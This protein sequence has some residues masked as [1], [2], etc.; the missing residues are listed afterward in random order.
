[1]IYDRLPKYVYDGKGYL[2]HS[3][4][5]IDPFIQIVLE[6]VG[7]SD[8]RSDIAIDD[9]LITADIVEITTAAVPTTSAT[10]KSQM[11]SSTSVVGCAVAGLQLERTWL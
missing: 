9:V 2:Q 6:G 8:Y 1:M 10:S 3:I 5:K 4:Y 7:G 11:V